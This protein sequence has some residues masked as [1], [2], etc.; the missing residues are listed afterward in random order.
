MTIKRAGCVA[1]SLMMLLAGQTPDARVWTSVQMPYFFQYAPGAGQPQPGPSG[2]W[3]F[4]FPGVVSTPIPDELGCQWNA[5]SG[6]P[7]HS[8]NYWPPPF[9]YA[10]PYT[11]ASEFSGPILRGYGAVGAVTTD[12]PAPGG[13]RGIGFRANIP[14]VSW[15]NGSQQVGAM[16]FSTDPC[17]SGDLEYGFAHYYQSATTQFYFYNYS[18]CGTECFLV[19]TT[20]PNPTSPPPSVPVQQCSAAINLPALPPNNN[21][22]YNYNY[23]ALVYHDLPSGHYRFSISVEDLETNTTFWACVADPLNTP[24]FLS[25]G[26][27]APS[28]CQ[29]TDYVDYTCTVNG[30]SEA[31]PISRL[32]YADHGTA[33]AGVVNAPNTAFA[34]Q[35]AMTVSRVTVVEY[36]N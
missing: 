31:Y 9:W 16:Y 33:V 23:T 13:I 36:P 32:Y 18:N 12:P 1:V 5:P 25:P 24:N 14:A 2:P 15:N 22:N 11:G 35:T 29:P 10:P 17:F 27:S 3:K 26:G 34:S 8:P 30:K 19:G 28:N 6:P 21:G 20:P 4:L 7:Y